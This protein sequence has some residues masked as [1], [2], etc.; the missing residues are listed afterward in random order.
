[1]LKGSPP[2]GSTREASAKTVDAILFVVVYHFLLFEMPPQ[3]VAVVQREFPALRSGLKY[4]RAEIVK[5]DGTDR[6][7]VHWCLDL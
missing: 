4:V 2:I 5:G 3:L 6:S 7:P 1:L